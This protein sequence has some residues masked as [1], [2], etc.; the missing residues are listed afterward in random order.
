VA[1]AADRAAFVDLPWAVYAHDP[2][3]VPPL[4]S[5]MHALIGGPKRNPWFLHGRAAF[6]LAR[7]DGRPV[8]R[9]SAQVC[10]LVQERRQGLGQWGLFEVVDD[11]PAVGAALIATAED[12]LRQQGMVQAEGPISISIWD[13]PGL[14]VQGFDRAPVVMMGHHRPAYEAMVLGAGYGG[15]KDL[16]AWALTVNKPFPDL[17]NR[18]VAAGERNKR[19]RVRPVDMRRFGE[20]AALIL[21][22]LNEAW[23]NNW[24]FVP[25]TPAEVSHVGKKLKPIVYPHLVRVAEYDGEPVA[26][27]ITLPD[28]NQLTRDL[29]GRLFPFG[30]A[31][32]LWR[33]RR[34]QVDWMRV[35]L[36]GVRQS[37][38][39][40]RTASL[41]AFMMI[42][43]IR[44][45]A[46]ALHGA[47]YGEIGWILEDN[48]PMV[49]I[50]EA[51]GARIRKTYRIYRRDL[52]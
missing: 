37:L 33:L 14:L 52:G 43:Y 17:V 2:H 7:R 42:E 49:S 19:I 38:Q 18:I 45:D 22:I 39:G 40:T 48:G 29:N 5:E 12:W 31:R 13:E 34:P 36:M 21:D 10:D 8:G 20:E 6:F 15:V 11:D 46:V 30:W 4:K 41:L 27:M 35:P 23:S 24:G 26:F 1:G 9:I 44:R 28:I 51:I 32:L 16:H 3:W 25:L 47:T 50:A